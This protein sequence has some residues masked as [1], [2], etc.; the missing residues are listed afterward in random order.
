[1]QEII[2]EEFTK[3]A[4]PKPGIN[5]LKNKI[6]FLISDNRL[7]SMPLINSVLVINIQIVMIVDSLFHLILTFALVVIDFIFIIMK[8][9]TRF[10]LL[11]DLVGS[12]FTRR[13]FLCRMRHNANMSR[14]E[15]LIFTLVICVCQQRTHAATGIVTGSPTVTLPGPGQTVLT[16][17][18]TL[19]S[20]PDFLGVN[21]YIDAYLG[22][23]FAQPPVGELRFADPLPYVIHGSYNATENRDECLQPSFL[24]NLP[25]PPE[26][27]RDI[28]EDCLYL[29][30]YT[31]SPKVLSANK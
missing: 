16:G 20:E 11:N 1:M 27:A 25:S 14:L 4:L 17:I 15:I 31:P 7:I 30:I 12:C 6:I 22:V 10:K 3:W 13:V 9:S 29:T 21:K 2:G 8:I 23:P 26:L 24:S 28:S 5:G 19:Y 18:T